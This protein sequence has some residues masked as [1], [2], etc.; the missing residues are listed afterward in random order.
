MNQTDI[1]K[2]LPLQ[3]ERVILTALEEHDIPFLNRFFQD[4]AALTFY[5]PTTAR[6]LNGLQVRSLLQDWNDGRD[7]F[8]FAVRTGARLIGLVNL[9]SLDWPNSHVEIGIAL[10]EPS[11]RGHGLAGEALALLIRYC[12]AELGL[13]RLWARIIEDNAPSLRLFDKAG[14]Q[15]EGRLRQH[16]L[17]RGVYRDMVILGLMRPE[18]QEQPDRVVVQTP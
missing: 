4:M 14:F 15:V 9:D 11:A 10:T 2:N 3:G 8:V 6:P 18:W 5:I 12:F 13:H 17:R 1:T 16:V 7:S